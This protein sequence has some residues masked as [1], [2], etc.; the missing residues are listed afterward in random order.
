MNDLQTQNPHDVIANNGEDRPTVNREVERASTHRPHVRP[1]WGGRV[2]AVCGF[3]LLTGSLSL[4]AWGN[5][6]REQQV[7]A[8]ARQE[9][10]CRPTPACPFYHVA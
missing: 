8:T 4:G 1:R 2:F 9:H 7:M 5:Y 6:S 10:R 3:V